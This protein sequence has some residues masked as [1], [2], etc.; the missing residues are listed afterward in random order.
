AEL[1][2]NLTFPEPGKKLMERKIKINS[3]TKKIVKLL[4]IKPDD[5][6]AV[7]YK[8][9]IL[10]AHQSLAHDFIKF[11]NAAEAAQVISSG[12]NVSPENEALISIKNALETPERTLKD[13]EKIKIGQLLEL[14]EQRF[15]DAKFTSPKNQSSLDAYREI[16]IIN[17]H[18]SKAQLGVRQILSIYEEKIDSL[19]NTDLP[20]ANDTLNEALELFPFSQSL[21]QLQNKIKSRI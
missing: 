11:D 17:P 15:S 2:A 1:I 8:N 3:M 4:K 9:K 14:A 7:Q 10:D 12:L 20:A 13:S 16:L 18:S 6:K 21:I 19:I 5:E